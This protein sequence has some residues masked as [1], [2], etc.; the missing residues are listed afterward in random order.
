MENQIQSTKNNTDVVL[1]FINVALCIFNFLFIFI[2]LEFFILGG[3]FLEYVKN[4]IFGCD[5]LCFNYSSGFFPGYLLLFGVFF[6]QIHFLNN[7]KYKKIISILLSI[8]ITVILIAVKI[9][10]DHP[11]PAP[12]F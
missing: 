8:I 11:H 7:S 2:F 5:K 10:M 12:T 1:S 6:S 9:Q 4:I 3:I